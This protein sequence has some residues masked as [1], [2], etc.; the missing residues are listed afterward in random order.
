MLPALD[1]DE[2]RRELE[3]LV[4]AADART[5]QESDTEARSAD[6]KRSGGAA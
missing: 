1:H 2:A 3:Q 6:S 4:L 5:R